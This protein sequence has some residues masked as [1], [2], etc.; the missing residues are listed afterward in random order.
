VLHPFER[1]ELRV[2]EKD[3]ERTVVPA[4]KGRLLPAVEK[5]EPRIA[6]GVGKKRGKPVVVPVGK[7]P[8]LVG[9]IW[10]PRSVAR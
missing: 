7:K 6:V 5:G 3:E 8:V 10:Q 4:Q 1:K 9:R 2:V